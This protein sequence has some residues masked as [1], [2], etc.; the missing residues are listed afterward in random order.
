MIPQVRP[1][2]DY[3]QFDTAAIKSQLSSRGLTTDGTRQQLVLRLKEEV[4]KA[5]DAYNENNSTHLPLFP[6]NQ[7]FNSKKA[8]KTPEQIEKE[9]AALALKRQ[10][11]LKRKLEHEKR[12]EEARERKRLKKAEKAKKQQEQI[13]RQKKEKEQRQ[14]CEAFLGFDVRN[15]EQQVRK[16]LDPT[17]AKIA[18]CSYDTVAKRF[19]VKFISAADAT[20]FT[21]GITMK[22]PRKLKFD[23]AVSILPSPVESRCVMFLYPMCNNHPDVAKANA[24]C[25]TNGLAQKKD[26]EVLQA[27]IQSASNTFSSYGTIV[28]IYRERGFL[29]VNFTAASGA[30]KMLE[31]AK[32]FNDC[33]FIRLQ[34]GTPTKLDK[35]TVDKELGVAKATKPGKTKQPSA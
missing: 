26:S 14:M 22:K 20:N 2:V 23:S 31:N 15:F 27:W 13:L 21:K 12:V 3:T 11:K 5:W 24:W 30:T 7:K 17:N 34:V 35:R 8:K 28:N 4:D 33:S 16:K 29:V 1:Q 18:S 9:N 19:K 25:E 6:N 10:E 32:T